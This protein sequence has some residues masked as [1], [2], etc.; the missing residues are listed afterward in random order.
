[1]K[2]IVLAL[3][4]LITTTAVYAQD[5]NSY[6]ELLRSDVKTQT[7]TIITDAMKFSEKEAAAFWPIYTDYEHELVKLGDEKL[8]MI[9]DYAANY[10]SMTEKKADQLTSNSFKFLNNRLKLKEKYFKKFSKAIGTISA[11]KYMQVD[12]Q[13]QLVIDLQ[14]ASALPMVKVPLK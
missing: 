13:I 10:D 11:A 8:A 12:R 6:I 5:V 4:L 7:R 3:I 14:I 2:T 1:M 9:K